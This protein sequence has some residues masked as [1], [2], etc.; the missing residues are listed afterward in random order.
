MADSD[1][2]RGRNRRLGAKDQGYSSIGWV[3]SGQ[4]VERSC[5]TVYGL[6]SAQGDEEHGFLDSASKPRSTVSPGLASKLVATVFVVWPQNHSLG[7]PGLGLKT[8]SCG[9]VIW[10]TKSP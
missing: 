10:P 1:E 5:D 3:L 9:F 6:H 2:D 8:S 4:M 7:C